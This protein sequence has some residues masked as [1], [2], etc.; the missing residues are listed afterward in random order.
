MTSTKMF[1]K[2]KL[3]L[4]KDLK[5]PPPG[6]FRPWRS[7][8]VCWGLV[9]RQPTSWTRL[10][11]PQRSPDDDDEVINAWVGALENEG[12]TTSDDE[13]MGSIHELEFTERS[14]KEINQTELEANAL[15]ICEN[16]YQMIAQEVNTA[17]KWHTNGNTH[18]VE[19]RS[20]MGFKQGLMWAKRDR[21]R[22]S[23][24]LVENVLED[25]VKQ[26]NWTQ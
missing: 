20:L 9:R 24:K 22:Q 16:G 5:V 17:Y 21:K 7:L 4:D 11:L 26:R 6:S 18:I 12:Q 1:P 8:N 3:S 10:I 15:T 2:F 19:E 25:I 13:E 14:Q 23:F